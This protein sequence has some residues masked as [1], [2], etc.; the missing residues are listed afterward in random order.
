M[1]QPGE[2]DWRNVAISIIFGNG[3]MPKMSS[4]GR[5]G[6]RDGQTNSNDLGF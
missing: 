2:F 1:A 5:V 3:K 6:G 4:S